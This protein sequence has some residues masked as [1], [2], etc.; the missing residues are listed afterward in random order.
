[1]RVE[2]SKHLDRP[3]NQDVEQHC[4]EDDGHSRGNGDQDNLTALTR[5]G[6]GC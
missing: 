3:A 2:A 4:E 5:D 1:M 6:E